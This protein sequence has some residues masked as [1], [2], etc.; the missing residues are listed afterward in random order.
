MKTHPTWKIMKTL[1][2]TSHLH[3]INVRSGK[4]MYLD[5]HGRLMT[6]EGKLYIPRL[7][8]QWYV[9]QN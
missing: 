8:D 1:T 9:K 4:E 5:Q 2:H 6:T 7:S 3:I